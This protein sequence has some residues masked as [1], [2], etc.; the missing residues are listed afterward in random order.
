MN[1]HLIGT[2]KFL[3]MNHHETGGLVHKDPSLRVTTSFPSSPFS[4]TETERERGSGCG[5]SSS[6]DRRWLKSHLRTPGRKGLK[7]NPFPLHCGTE[8]ELREMTV[9][10]GLLELPHTISSEIHCLQSST[11]IKFFSLPPK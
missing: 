11:L 7:Q 4:D 1:V 6:K 3:D 5:S 8:L 2:Y 9:I 10:R